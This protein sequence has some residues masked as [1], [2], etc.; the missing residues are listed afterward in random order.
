MQTPTGAIRILRHT[1]KYFLKFSQTAPKCYRTYLSKAYWCEEDWKKRLESPLLK[2]VNPG[3]MFFDIDK[4]FQ[5]S[6]KVCAVDVDIFANC[7]NEQVNIDEVTTLLEK[8]RSTPEATN[9]MP[10]THHAVVRL[11]LSHN[12]KSILWEVLNNRMKYGIFP[13]ALCYNLL[14]DTFLENKD[15]AYAA[16]IATLLMIQE[17][18]DNPI[19]TAMALYSCHRYLEKPDEWKAP[20]VVSNEPVEEVKVRV[21][22]L[23]EPFFDDHFDLTE[24]SDLVGKTLAFFGKFVGGVEGRSCQLRGLI[25]YKK[26]EKAVELMDQWV[27]E[28][29]PDLVFKEVVSLIEKD[30]EEIFKDESNEGVNKVRQLLKKLD[31]LKL[32]E[33]SLADVLEENIKSAIKSQEKLDMEKVK[34]VW[35]L[36]FNFKFFENLVI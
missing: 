12:A 35:F 15:F 19:S 2:Q 3:E 1:E 6:G 28:N 5:N 14:M 4:K 17:D 23:R 31:G 32:K 22:Y 9:I 7:V 13:D 11:I 20:V 36:L 34:Q 16:R 30:N 25:L 27:K 26:Y 21:K 29:K 10:S 18:C 24:P 8:L 33:G